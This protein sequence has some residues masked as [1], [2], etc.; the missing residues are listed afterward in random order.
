MTTGVTNGHYMRF[1]INGVS[2]GKAT[3]CSISFSAE[4][5]ELAHKDTTGDG[6]G[7]VEKAP[8]QKSGSGSTSGLYAEDDNAAAVLFEAFKNGD[9]LDIT[10]TTEETGDK[11]WAG[12]AFITSL[13]INAPNNEN[14][15]YSCSWEFNGEVTMET[16]S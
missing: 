6:G 13:E 8:G 12:E 2:L 16:V 11:L 15:S 1:F 10:Y 7:W 5:R 3:E 4:M 9:P 14:V